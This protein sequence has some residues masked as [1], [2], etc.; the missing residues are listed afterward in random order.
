MDS[1]F[2]HATQ[3]RTLAQ[4]PPLWL[5][6][7][8]LGS[9]TVG[10]TIISP[11]L[12]AIA[13]DFRVEDSLTQWLLSG[14]FI[15]VAFSQLVYGPL[16]DRYGRKAPLLTGL[17]LYVIGGAAG[18]LAPSME[19]LIA[20]RV[21]QGLGAAAI[22]S[23]VRAIVNDS[24]ERT[25]GAPAG[26]CRTPISHG[27]LMSEESARCVRSGSPFHIPARPP[28]ADSGAKLAHCA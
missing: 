12:K 16:S 10:I 9:G 28:V 11:T 13:E 25:E 18:A 14:Y 24:Y 20:A 5:L 1:G 27:P 26:V 15:A 22:M 17:A 8:I 7:L 2:D 19:W 3:P 23:I 4:K 21:L 6:V